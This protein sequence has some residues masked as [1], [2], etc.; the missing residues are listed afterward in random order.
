[1]I[2]ALQGKVSEKLDG[3]FVLQVGGVFY[4]IYAGER[5][6]KGLSGDVKIFCSPHIKDESAPELYGFL[7]EQ[8]LQFFELLIG[9]SGVGRKIGLKILDGGTVQEISSAIAEGK[10]DLFS[11]VPGIGKKT[12]DRIIL[13]LREKMHL[14]GSE[15]VVGRMEADAEVLGALSQLGFSRD[16]I[17]AAL[18]RMGDEPVQFE[19]RLKKALKEVSK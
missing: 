13:E 15:Q 6:L 4:K 8:S 3:F 10:A 11:H 17:S 1:M 16:K 18:K 7:D 12:A 2:Y 19:E 14:V 9:V 5:A